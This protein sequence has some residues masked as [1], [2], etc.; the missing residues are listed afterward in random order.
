MNDFCMIESAFENKKELNKVV[1]KLLSDK[2]VS[3]CQVIN[4]ESTWNWKHERESAQEFLLLMKTRKVY[5]KEIYEVI[6]S[7]HSYECFEF[8]IF[9]LTSENKNYLNWIKEETKND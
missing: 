5:A 1:D 9:D 3:S 2:L 4:S 8:A 7:I 6:K